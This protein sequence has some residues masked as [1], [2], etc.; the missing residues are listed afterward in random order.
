MKLLSLAVVGLV[1]PVVI[2]GS[3]FGIDERNTERGRGDAP[4]GKVNNE[5]RE[6]YQMPDRFSN[7]AIVCDKYG[8]AVYTNTRGEANAAIFALKDGCE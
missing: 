7:F 3:L 2:F 5:A 6:V 8:N 4:V 1:A